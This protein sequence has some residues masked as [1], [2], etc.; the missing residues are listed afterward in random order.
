MHDLFATIIDLIKRGEVRIS[1][2]GYEELAADNILV[3]DVLTDTHEAIVVEAYPDYLK[4]PCLL[5]LQRDQQGKPLHVL[6]GIPKGATSPAVL[7]TAYRP[8]PKRWSNDY[9]RRL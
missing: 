7:V 2:H 4:G 5:L 3:R 9:L 6:W 8:D 1:E